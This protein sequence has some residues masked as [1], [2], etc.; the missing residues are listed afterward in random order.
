[1]PRAG[2]L[3]RHDGV[4]HVLVNPDTRKRYVQQNK[5]FKATIRR[6]NIADLEWHDLRR[7]AGCRWLQSGRTMQEVSTMLGHS[8]VQVTERRYAFLEAEKVALAIARTKTGTSD[9]QISEKLA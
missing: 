6:A 5:G 8:S 2:K 7:T 9:Q 1:M 4:P 3:Q